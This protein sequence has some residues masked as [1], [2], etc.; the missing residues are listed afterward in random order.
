MPS[1]TAEQGSTGPSGWAHRDGPQ[2]GASA[3]GLS[4]GLSVTD[5]QKLTARDFRQGSQ[6]SVPCGSQMTR[7]EHDRI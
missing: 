6:S 2:L 4:W 3:G 7:V 1:A 5:A